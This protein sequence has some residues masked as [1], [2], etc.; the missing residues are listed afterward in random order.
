MLSE[1]AAPDADLELD[2]PFSASKLARQR[3]FLERHTSAD[4]AASMS[5]ADGRASSARKPGLAFDDVADVDVGRLASIHSS[6]SPRSRRTPATAAGAFG[7]GAPSTGGSSA[8]GGR[9]GSA[10]GG[11]PRAGG[12]FLS[13]EEYAE[14]ERTALR[15]RAGGR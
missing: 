2:A 15:R 13:L 6:V 12:Q 8:L 10:V 4:S 5:T 9:A 14:M 11:S 3:T 7:G 1:E